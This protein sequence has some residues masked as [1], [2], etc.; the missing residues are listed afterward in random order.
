MSQPGNAL[1]NLVKQNELNSAQEY[2]KKV[3]S[4]MLQEAADTRKSYETFHTNLAL[5]SSGTLALSMTYL[6]YLKNSGAHVAHIKFLV[7]SWTCLIFTI[8]LSL[9]VSFL[10]SHHLSYGRIQEYQDA[11]SAQKEAEA[12]AVMIV[13]VA[14]MKPED[15]PAYRDQLLDQAKKRAEEGVKMKGKEN[16][17]YRLWRVTGF[18]SRTLFVLGLTFLYVFAVLNTLQ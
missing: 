4:Q 10:Y 1:D 3:K 14:N 15:L 7:A 2:A 9:F 18:A 17:Y 16:L 8:P 13:P 6:G 5:F 12:D 11:V